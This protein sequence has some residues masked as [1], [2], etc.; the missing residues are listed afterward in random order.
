[1]AWNPPFHI[2]RKPYRAEAGGEDVVK[3]SVSDAAILR[4][5]NLQHHESSVRWLLPWLLG[6]R[7]LFRGPWT[8]ST[9][10][11]PNLTVAEVVPDHVGW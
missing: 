6:Y 5:R 10:N 9:R 4:C 7:I 1:M 11:P 3:A 2:E 8:C